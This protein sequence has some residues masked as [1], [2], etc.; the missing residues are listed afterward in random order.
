MRKLADDV[1][2]MVVA[3]SPSP[4][5]RKPDDL[6]V[7][8]SGREIRA[9]FEELPAGSKYLRQIV[10]QPELGGIPANYPGTSEVGLPAGKYGAE[11]GKYDVIIGHDSIGRVLLVGSQCVW[12]GP[13]DSLMPVAFDAEV[14]RRKVTDGITRC[15]VAHARPQDFCALDLLEEFRGFALGVQKTF[16]ANALIN[17]MIRSHDAATSSPATWGHGRQTY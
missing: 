2:A 7:H 12:A 1:A 16:H 11:V 9:G 10:P 13:N 8:I 4:F 14:R 15:Y 3:K 5:D 17:F 6:S